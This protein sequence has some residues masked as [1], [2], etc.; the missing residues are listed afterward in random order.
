M[1][2]VQQRRTAWAYTYTCMCHG[3]TGVC[4]STQGDQLDDVIQGM[5]ERKQKDYS[6][7]VFYRLCDI[8][9]GSLVAVA[10]NQEHPKYTHTH[11]HVVISSSIMD[12]YHHK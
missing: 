8:H 6:W 7:L 10:D 2:Q 1:K 3:Q 11:T 4:Y 5:G 12:I 9:S